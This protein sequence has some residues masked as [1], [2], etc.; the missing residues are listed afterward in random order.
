MASSFWHIC[1]IPCITCLQPQRI[2]SWQDFAA[3]GYA[4]LSLCCFK[5]SSVGGIFS[6]LPCAMC[7]QHLSCFIHLSLR[8]G[9][10]VEDDD[11]SPVSAGQ[12][13]WCS[14][15]GKTNCQTHQLLLDMPSM[16]DMPS[17]C[18]YRRL[19]IQYHFRSQHGRKAKHCK[20]L[21]R[22]NWQQHELGCTSDVY[23]C[24]WQPIQ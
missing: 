16:F 15:V 18:L 5:A 24:R 23:Q 8:T 6:V 17:F 7:Q 2:S 19:I 3:S 22:C 11:K 21:L 10:T 12:P 14:V 13:L 20:T 1:K 9:A 4:A